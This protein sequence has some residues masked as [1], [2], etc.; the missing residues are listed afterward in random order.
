MKYKFQGIVTDG[1][2]QLEKKEKFNG[3]IK[4][5][6]GKQIEVIV[7]KKSS[8]RSIA[9]NAYFHAVTC[10][11]W[12]EYVG[13]DIV[14]MKEILKAKFLKTT[15]KIKG[16]DVEYV[17]A[18]SSLTVDGMKEFIDQCEKLGIEYGIIMPDIDEVEL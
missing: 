13:C 8:A 14:T 18:T 15:V 5:V 2:M 7:Q 4:A 11:Y 9:Q 12:G 6:E 1:K 3:Y 10:K 17:R 16:K